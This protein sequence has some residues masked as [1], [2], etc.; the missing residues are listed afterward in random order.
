[1]QVKAQGSKLA[2]SWL[3][4]VGALVRCGHVHMSAFVF[5]RVFVHACVCACISMHRCVCVCVC[6][7]AR[8]HARVCVRV[9]RCNTLHVSYWPSLAC[10]F[11]P[12]AHFCFQH[13]VRIAWPITFQ[14]KPLAH[15]G[16]RRQ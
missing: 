11:V 14:P 12:R 1:M 6:V 3:W 16:T 4:Q 2:K 13:W 8:A 15:S 5:A 9:Y 7:C 10:S